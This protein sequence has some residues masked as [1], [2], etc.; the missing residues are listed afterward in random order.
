MTF[1]LKIG[2]NDVM[3]SFLYIKNLSKSKAQLKQDLIVLSQLKFK[4]NGF[5]VEFGATNG[6]NLSN[7][8]LLENSFNWKGVLSEPSPQWHEVLKENR[9]YTKIKKNVFGQR[10]EKF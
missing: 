8:Y 4:E 3:D 2:V 6:L 7:S 1:R 9:K 10:V 5:F